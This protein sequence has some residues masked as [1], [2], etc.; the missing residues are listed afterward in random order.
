MRVGVRMRNG[1]R[2]DLRFVFYNVENL[3]DPFDDSL[4]IDEEFLP[5]GIRNW[6]WERFL[7]KEQKI[8]KVLASV[9]GWKP[10]EI[11]GLCE[12][13]NRFVL[14]WLIRKTPL[15]K[16]NYRLIHQ[17][18]PDERGIDVA[19]LYIPTAFT[20]II[21]GFYTVPDPEESADK[22]PFEIT[23]KLKLETA[24]GLR[25]GLRPELKSEVIPDFRPDHTRDVLYV[26]GLVRV[27]DTLHL[28]ICH[29]PSRWQGYLESQPSRMA[30]A[31][32]V[33]GLVDS[34][35][36]ADRAS[37]II[38]AGDMNDELTDPSLKDVLWVQVK[39]SPDADTGLYHTG[40]ST[41]SGNFGISRNDN[42]NIPGTLKYQGGWYEFDHIFVSGSFFSD[43][44]LFVNPGGK[45]I[46]APSFLLENDP[47]STGVKP[48]RT[49]NG[50]RYQG[51][52]SDHLPV[53]IDIYR[54]D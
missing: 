49:Y 31:K 17:D 40:G 18:S 47:G 45:R 7:E 6:T 42:R 51:G 5:W 11:I 14:N 26:K 23:Q 37:R 10:P 8:Y 43:S 29:W 54:G 13:E 24:P 15:L 35:L 46:F 44:G 36:F 33:K 53:F 1:K 16:Y 34:I 27:G 39:E 19:L 25:P 52:F 32:V 2:G 4:T 9:G 41:G 21:S 22:H 12:V 20:P 30:A 3:F 38:V 28:I 48:Y 50:Y